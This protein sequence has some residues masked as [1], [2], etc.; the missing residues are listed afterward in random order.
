MLNF[1]LPEEFYKITKSFNV[2]SL[3]MDIKEDVL[4]MTETFYFKDINL[5]QELYKSLLNKEEH[6]EFYSKKSE[7]FSLDLEIIPN[8][9]VVNI[10]DFIPKIID[11]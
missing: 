11:I 3:P 5:A 4:S 8:F 2:S 6:L 10:F 1:E 9:D 7:Y